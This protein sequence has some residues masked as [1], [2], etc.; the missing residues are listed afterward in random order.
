M[1]RLFCAAAL[2][3]ALTTGSGLAAGDAAA[4]VHHAIEA[5]LDPD[6]GQLEVTDIVTVRGRTA[7]EFGLASWLEVERLLLDGRPAELTGAGGA[8]NV[9]LP[10][11][12]A[13]RVELR[14]RGVVPPLPPDGGGGATPSAVSGPEGSYLSGYSGWI[15]VTGD[16][17]TAY[18]LDVAVPA[19][20]RAVATG[21]LEEEILGKRTNRAVFAADY[22]AEPP[23]LF[24]GPYTVT[25][26]REDNIRIRTWFHAELAGLAAD[27]LS[28]SGRFLW[29]YS[30]EIGPYPFP[31]FHVIS[32]PLP[33]GLGFPNLT[34]IGRTVL[35]LPFIRGRSLAHEVLH[36]WWGNGVAVDYATGNWA[37]GLTT[38]MADYALAAEE[39][40]GRAEEMRLAWLRDYAALPADR[41]VPVTAFA[42]KRHDAGQVVGYNKV[43][44]IFHMLRQELGD[45]AFAA[46]LRL[47]WRQQRFRIAGWAK[48]GEAFEA[49]A[50]RDLDWFFQQWLEQAGAPRLS[51]DEARA[52][53][54]GD[55]FRVA[56]TLRQ[57]HPSYRLGIPVVIETAAGPVRRRIVLDKA[58]MTASVVLQDRPVAVHVDPEH[59]LFR[60]LLPGEAPP[61]LRDVT[62]AADAVTVFAAGADTDATARQLAER[63][64]DTPARFESAQSS[65]LS[66]A[67]PLLVIGI[68]PQ[69]KDFLSRAG[70]GG[71]PDSLAG[72]GTAR[73]W[74]ARRDGGAPLLVVVADDDEALAALLRPLP[75]YGGKSYLVFEG[76]RAVE[77]GIWPVEDSPLSRRLDR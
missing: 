26:R 41:D 54:E 74:T 28:D 57:D 7:L 67:A 73:V 71:V 50:G 63:L 48:L 2:F 12:D 58:T 27:Y 77:T 34:Y 33:V 1:I 9:K 17:W 35:P 24:A 19:P 44:F 29:R 52:T 45:T 56:L 22:P 18:R 72:R 49:A 68:T 3:V 62:L 11:T 53:K 37:E 36:N 4:P 14:L 51:L 75:H 70:I 55:G 65:E 76:R 39:G 59:D 60:R 69:V 61:I 46:G 23:A 15:P 38:Y 32:S 42:G 64:L 31:D 25:E 21:R 20:H 6:S 10:D 47:F 40:A 30:E 13:H 16:D 43:A 5:R 66:L 8:W